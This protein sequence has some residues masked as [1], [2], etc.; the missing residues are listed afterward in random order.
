MIK[1][2]FSTVACPDSTLGEVV[3][4]ARGAG[5]E[6]VELRTFGDASRRF[7][8]DPALTDESK[9]REMFA[10]RG[11]EILSLATSLRFDTRVSPPVLGLYLSDADRAVREGKRAVDLAVGLECPF[12]RVFAFEVPRREKRVRA[13]ARIISRLRDVLDHANNTGVRIILENGGSFPRASDIGQI[14]RECNHPLIGASY[15][16]AAAVAD[17]EDAGTAISV[18]GDRLWAAR[19]KDLRDGIPCRLGEGDLPCRRFV[20]ALAAAGFDGPLIF[21]WD[22]AWLPSLPPADQVL[23]AAARTLFDWIAESG[24]GG[25]SS[26]RG[27]LQGSV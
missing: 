15:S 27:R 17:G 4:R 16:L 3:Q 26:G 7:A 6:A 1:P 9:V 25:S 12:V 20:G 10:S 21:E 24:P 11:I 5:F 22:R 13:L 8:C 14:I 19:I 2:A 23:P 18:L